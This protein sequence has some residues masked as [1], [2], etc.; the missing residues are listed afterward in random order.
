MTDIQLIVIHLIAALISIITWIAWW[1]ILVFSLHIFSLRLF[2]KN[3]EPFLDDLST[4]SGVFIGLVT[5]YR[6]NDKESGGVVGFVLD[7][8]Y[9]VPEL[10]EQLLSVFIKH[11][12]NF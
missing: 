1:F 2:P 8:L 11:I 10:I 6:Y 9:L 12:N 4:V 5:I 7:I 3:W